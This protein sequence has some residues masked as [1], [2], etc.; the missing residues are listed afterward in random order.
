MIYDYQT[1]NISFIKMYKE[2][3]DLGIQ[4]NK[5]HLILYD[6]DLLGV[7]P[8]DSNLSLELQ[9]KIYKECIIN[10][11]Y[12]A[13]EVV[14]IPTPAGSCMYELHRGNLA[15]SFTQLLNI[16]SIEI[17][18]RQHYKT[19]SAVCFYSWMYL[20][21]AKNYNIAFSN[22]QLEDS[23]LN[24]KRLND[25]IDLLPIY[26]K[27]HMDPKYDTNNINLLRIA[28]NNNTIKALSTGKDKVSADRLGKLKSFLR[29]KTFLCLV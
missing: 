29:P 26:L 17:L 25:L 10:Y 3:K 21:V 24:I 15:T 22:K 9:A 1:K 23:Q 19:Y 14:R 18:P 11:W 27:S 13:R 16:N 28:S 20:F 2:L 7:D 6:K 12:Y 5:F 4:N 8:Y